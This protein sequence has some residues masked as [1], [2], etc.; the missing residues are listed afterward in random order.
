MS[1]AADLCF[2]GMNVELRHLRALAKVAELRSFSAAADELGLTQP[3]VT[4]T[5]QQLEDR[6]GVALVERT[7][8]HVALTPAGER[9][10]AD[11]RAIVGDVERALGRLRAETPLRLGFQWVLPS[12][13][14]TRVIAG[15]EAASGVVVDLIRRDDVRA[16]LLAGE[17]DA[18]LVRTA[19]RGEEFA[20]ATLLREERVGVVS[21]TGPL[22]RRRRMTWAELGTHP[23]VVNVVNGTTT[24]R[25]WPEDQR[26][27]QV[28]E[29]HNFDEWAELVAAGRGVGALPVSAAGSRLHPGLKTIRLTGAP[30]AHLWLV[31]RRHRDDRLLRQ[32]VD[33][34]RAEPM[35][36]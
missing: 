16:A 28:I 32:F 9:L 36:P 24:P 2:S 27:P 34:A 12:P 21:A 31:R 18:A 5:I 35:H 8:R 30:P 7:T 1:D 22:A 26:P 14:I 29:C 17:L 4:R 11:A 33:I 19:V 25:L 3:V 23:L 6:V 20:A 13:W 15:F 10:A